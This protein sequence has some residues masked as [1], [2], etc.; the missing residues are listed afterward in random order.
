MAEHMGSNCGDQESSDDRESDQNED[1]ET[2]G[3]DSNS[4]SIFIDFHPQFRNFDQNSVKGDDSKTDTEGSVSQSNK[5][6]EVLPASTV[7]ESFGLSAVQEVTK[8]GSLIMHPGKTYS[9]PVSYAYSVTDLQILNNRSIKIFPQ[10]L[11]GGEKNGSF[12]IQT[13]D[14]S[15]VGSGKLFDVPAAEIQQISASNVNISQGVPVAETTVRV[16]KE[17]KEACGATQEAEYDD[18]DKED[19][20]EIDESLADRGRKRRYPTSRPFKCSQCDHAF[21]Q[22]IHLKKHMSK[23]TGKYVLRL[24]LR[25]VYYIGLS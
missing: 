6:N 15:S 5:E 1:N 24:S 18:S 19:E 17:N 21:N 7:N 20:M 8:L 16:P 12:T 2:Q 10:T 14:A 13:N 4:N 11:D 3:E 23:H 22:R 9:I 25:N